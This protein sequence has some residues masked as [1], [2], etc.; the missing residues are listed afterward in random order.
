M[1]GRIS[2]AAGIFGKLLQSGGRNL[3]MVLGADEELYSMTQSPWQQSTTQRY[4]IGTRLQCGERVWRYAHILSTAVSTRGKLMVCTDAGVE[5]GAFLGAI[6]S[7]A[8]TFT[9]TSVGAY[10]ANR[11]ADGYILMVGGFVHKIK[12]HG[13]SVGA[14]SVVTFTI[15]EI[16][17]TAEV[18]AAGGLGII[19]ENPYANVD[20]MT[21]TGIGKGMGIIPNDWTPNNYVWLQTWGPCGVILTGSITMAKDTAVIT[22]NIAA[23]D[24]MLAHVGVVGS[25]GLQVVGDIYMGNGGVDWDGVSMGIV[26]LRIDP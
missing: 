1:S 18:A 10:I 4:P 21:H 24:T 23:A 14:G 16:F 22:T 6:V 25:D 26:W 19:Q 7:G 12:S 15:Y 8:R 2:R 17:T 9:W 13:A 20:N 11:Y 5:R 3:N